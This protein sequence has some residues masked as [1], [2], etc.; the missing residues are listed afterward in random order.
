MPAATAATGTT[1]QVIL[2]G[3]NEQAVWI[4]VVMFTLAQV[5]STWNFVFLFLLRYQR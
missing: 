1:Q 3:E 2:F 4:D 5:S